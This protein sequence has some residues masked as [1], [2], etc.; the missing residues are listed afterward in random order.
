MDGDFSEAVLVMGHRNYCEVTAVDEDEDETD[1]LSSTLA[2]ELTPCGVE[3]DRFCSC[4]EPGW[5]GSPECAPCDYYR[6][7]AQSRHTP[8]VVTNLWA[9]HV[10]AALRE[11]P[12]LAHEDRLLVVDEAHHAYS[13]ADS[14]APKLTL[15]TFARDFPQHAE[16]AGFERHLPIQVQNCSLNG[17]HSRVVTRESIQQRWALAEA[18]EAAAEDLWD[19]V[20]RDPG[21]DRADPWTRRATRYEDLAGLLTVC[22]HRNYERGNLHPNKAHPSEV[23]RTFTVEQGRLVAQYVDPSPKVHGATSWAASRLWMS[24]TLGDDLH[25]VWAP[26]HQ[27]TS[28]VVVTVPSTFESHR[29]PVFV[30]HRDTGG[31]QVKG[32]GWQTRAAVMQPLA[33]AIAA[34]AD[35]PAL[36]LVSSCSA[37]EELDRLLTLQGVRS[38]LQVRSGEA[39]AKAALRSGATV[40]SATMW[41]GVDLPDGECRRVI[42]AKVPY[43][44]VDALTEA[45]LADR[46]AP[47]KVQRLRGVGDRLQ[48][49][50]EPGAGGPQCAG[51]GDHARGRHLQA[52]GRR[53]ASGGRLR[54]RWCAG[55]VTS[56]CRTTTP[57]SWPPC[58]VGG[59]PGRPS[60]IGREV[61]AMPVET[62][63][64]CGFVARLVTVRVPLTSIRP[65]LCRPCAGSRGPGHRGRPQCP[66]GLI[67]HRREEH[68]M[69]DRGRHHHLS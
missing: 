62:C 38:Y 1:L 19:R 30:H 3:R 61:A 37:A 59:S 60:P 42:V 25:Q 2:P 21:S 51:L 7:L 22:V 56:G 68:P 8:L 52:A 58:Y 18:L 67:D 13:F 23:D 32:K 29:R 36:V 66:S 53:P 15:W 4:D 33:D 48:A 24:A 43:P 12:Y 34:L 54:T 11:K 28:P 17:L 47:G 65:R 64:R 20:A 9:L 35:V 69:S 46:G 6:A 39:D 14:L 5:C 16:A 49:G 40:V 50:A 41:T 55:A 10:D 63:R 57:L 45:R 44:V 31:V 27:V 26:L